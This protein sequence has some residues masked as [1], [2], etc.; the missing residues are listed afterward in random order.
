[1]SL[2]RV[3]NIVKKHG[4][5]TVVNN[6]SFT[7]ERMQ[8]IA[9][10]GE[11]GSGKTTL[12][13][14][15]AGLGQA[16]SGEVLFEDRPVKGVNEKLMA[17]YKGIAYLS[18]H[19]ELRNNYRVEEELMYANNLLKDSFDALVDV[20][21]IKHLLGRQ[22]QTLSGGERQRVALARLITQTPKLLLLDEPFSNMDLIHKTTLKAVVDFASERMRITCMLISHDPL[23]LLPWAD[24]LLVMQ[25]GKIIQRG[26]PMDVYRSPVNTYVAGLLGKYNLISLELATMLPGGFGRKAYVRP[27]EIAIVAD[28]AEGL[29]AKITKVLFYG[30]HYELEVFIAGQTLIVR[31]DKPGFMKGEVVNLS[32]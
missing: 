24:E 30:G 11:T 28:D 31:T 13:R 12:L 22:C 25:N 10:A 3:A 4:T 21:H 5:E 23:D 16:D 7:L 26:E 27:E 9:I 29:K 1:M 17:G 18:Q 8:K 15:V 6:V 19:F 32:I 14:I 20:C 2:L